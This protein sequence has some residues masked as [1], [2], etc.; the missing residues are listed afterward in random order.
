M[1]SVTGTTP[2]PMVSVGGMPLL[3]HVMR[4]Y[5]DQGQRRFVL[6]LGYLGEVIRAWFEAHPQAG[7]EVV[8]VDTGVDTPTAGRLA[9][10]S[11]ALDPEASFFLTYGDGVAD[12]DLPGLLAHHRQQGRL[13]TVTALRPRSR[14]GVLDLEGG[15]VSCF[16]EKPL[17]DQYVSGGFFVFE[18][19]V[20][21]R[22]DRLRPLED[23]TLA[24][25]AQDGELAAWRHE[26][27]W[28]SVDTPRDLAEINAL[29]DKGETPWLAASS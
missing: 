10:A 11:P 24:E 17:L 2:K 23:G 8:L 9:A 14:F 18:P 21:G 13:A 25:L 15:V 3:W 6:C 19:G 4:C 16:R 22:L 28:L 5:A 12:V 7:W 27:F 20:L 26:G 1:G 29:C